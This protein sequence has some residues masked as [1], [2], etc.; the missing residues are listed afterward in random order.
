[1][2]Q[3]AEIF[4]F[5]PAADSDELVV[6]FSSASATRLEGVGTLKRFPVNKLFI[7]DP[8]KNWYNGPIAGVSN[9]ADSLAVALDEVVSTFDR[10]KVTFV[11]SSMG[12]YG[13]LLLGSLLGVGQIRAVAPQIVL[14]PKIPHSPKVDVKYS[15]L[16][17]VIN[18][19]AEKSDVRIWFGCGELLDV[20]QVARCVG[21][22]GCTVNAVP[23]SLHNV[24]AHFKS[25]SL[26]PQFV[27]SLILGT[28][29][30]FAYGDLSGI[31]YAEIK[32]AIDTLHLEGDP[33]AAAEALQGIGHGLIDGGRLDQM[34]RAWLSA[35][36]VALARKHLQLA[37][38]I[39]PAN[40]E[41]L[42]ALGT[43]CIQQRDYANAV[44]S[45]A[46][47]VEKFPSSNVVFQ[48]QLAAAHRLNKDYH[49]ALE[50]IRAALDISNYWK[51]HYYAALTYQDMERYADAVRSFQK[52]A[53]LAPSFTKA[54]SLMLNCL[55]LHASKEARDNFGLNVNVTFTEAAPTSA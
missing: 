33:L 46:A 13:A 41:A 15:D 12:G 52:V 10:E 37:I 53:A 25:M 34:G 48:A 19:G 45:Y 49:S 54:S 55:A 23:G 6:Y 36:R 3:V 5:I 1:M 38:E 16:T 2:R 40:Y 9:D 39:N 21:I 7:R 27:D 8:G 43:A 35:G 14:N 26:L 30:D 51:A 29:F 22:D 18:Q 32:D 42:Y 17:K 44:K 47:A 11:G 24:M 20:Y 50:A 28:P 31:P 4:H